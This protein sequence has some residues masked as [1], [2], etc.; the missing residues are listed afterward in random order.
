MLTLRIVQVMLGIG[1]GAAVA[2]I[3]VVIVVVVTT[4]AFELLILHYAVQCIN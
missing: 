1:G 4:I 2:A 3:V